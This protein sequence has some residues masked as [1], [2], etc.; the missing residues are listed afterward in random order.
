MKEIHNKGFWEIRRET[1]KYN[2]YMKW[3]IL[4]YDD[5][6]QILASDWT[7]T[8]KEAQQKVETAI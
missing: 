6:M 7:K 1:S 4:F 2:K 3:H 5:Q 8:K